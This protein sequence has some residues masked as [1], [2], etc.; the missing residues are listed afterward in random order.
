M[1]LQEG[2]KNELGGSYGSINDT[3]E[4]DDRDYRIGESYYLRKSNKQRYIVSIF[5]FSLANSQLYNKSYFLCFSLLLSTHFN[6][7]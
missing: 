1:T 2:T 5:Q 7:M 6:Y 4:S 3:T